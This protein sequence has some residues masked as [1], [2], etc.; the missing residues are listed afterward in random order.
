MGNNIIQ[1]GWKTT[2]IG[3]LILLAALLSVFLTDRIGW[4][5]ATAPIL[6][7]IALIFT[8]DTI[9]DKLAGLFSTLSNT[10]SKPKSDA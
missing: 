10:L 6:I 3:L 1:K 8:P 5:E 7:G 2:V 9:L 4:G